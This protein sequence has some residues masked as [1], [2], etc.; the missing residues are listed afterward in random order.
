MV[1]IE[2]V[3]FHRKISMC[4]LIEILVTICEVQ[5]KLQLLKTYIKHLLRDTS[6][7]TVVSS[8]FCLQR[9]PST[10]SPALAKQSCSLKKKQRPRV[11][12]LA[13]LI[14]TCH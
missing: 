3:S 2:R 4:L 13:I 1:K 6:H 8:E 5:T 11:K 12:I 10:V 9:R 7:D 14:A